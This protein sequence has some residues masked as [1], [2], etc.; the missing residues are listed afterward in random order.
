MSASFYN[1]TINGQG[2]HQYKLMKYLH[3]IS[4]VLISAM[5]CAQKSSSVSKS[6]SDD[7]KT[8]KLSYKVMADDKF[9]DYENSFDV[10][11]W[12]KTQKNLLVDHI[13]D[14]LNN[15]PSKQPSVTTDRTI[16]IDDNGQTLT[17]TVDS[18]AKDH[19]IHYSN[20]FDIKRKTQKEKDAMVRKVLASLG[21]KEEQ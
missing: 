13:I 6:I 19:E 21:L 20:S 7:D 12:S 5:T 1:G 11:G 2:C 17:V 4:F 18:K 16:K 14:S 9:I 8:L 3:L 10:A 15:A